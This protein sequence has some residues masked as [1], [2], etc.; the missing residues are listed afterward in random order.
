M[1]ISC[2]LSC[3]WTSGRADL[4]LKVKRSKTT[5]IFV[6]ECAVQ[7]YYQTVQGK[8]VRAEVN[9]FDLAIWGLNC[10]FYRCQQECARCMCATLGWYRS[11]D[12]LLH[13]RKA[14]QIERW[15][16]QTLRFCP[17]SWQVLSTLRL[18][19]LF[20]PRFRVPAIAMTWCS[21]RT[22]QAGSAV[23]AWAATR[24][25]ARRAFLTWETFPERHCRCEMDCREFEASCIMM[26]NAQLFFK[27]TPHGFL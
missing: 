18:L 20:A 21:G 11:W 4:A 10:W 8:V 2:H 22:S 19:C 12:C 1:G 7:L 6:V 3:T 26:T 5:R 14:Q 15:K 13:S 27:R 24:W 17:P 23:P 9:K 16:S 25:E